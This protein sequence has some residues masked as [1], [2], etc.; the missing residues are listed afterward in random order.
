[1]KQF[2]E[3]ILIWS[4]TKPQRLKVCKHFLVLS[5]KTPYSIKS[6]TSSKLYFY[7]VILC[8]YSFALTGSEINTTI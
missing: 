1:M 3:E 7:P 2:K 5:S 4:F 6:N 8:K